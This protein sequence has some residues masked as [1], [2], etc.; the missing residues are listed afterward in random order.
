MAAMAPI[1]AAAIT[2]APQPLPLPQPGTST[3]RSSP[4]CTESL[5]DPNLLSHLLSKGDKSRDA[6]QYCKSV[7]EE[8]LNSIVTWAKN[9]PYFEQLP[10]K[11]VKYVNYE[12]K[13]T[14]Q[15]FVQKTV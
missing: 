13:S 4:L 15:K 12:S 1:A 5:L 8:S 3:D 14:Y 2:S 10:A 6:F 11:M 9:A 7:I